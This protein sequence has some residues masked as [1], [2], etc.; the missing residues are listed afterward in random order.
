MINKV[1]LVGN[2]TRD[3]EMLA[4]AGKPMTKMRLATNHQWKD[5]DGNRQEAAEFHSVVAFGRLAEVC[6][7]Y[8]SKGRPVYLEG[9]L[10]TREYA[11]ADGLRRFSTEIVAETVKLLQSRDHASGADAAEEPVDDAAMAD[12]LEAGAGSESP[13]VA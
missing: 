8:C 9:R 2:M 1:I 12:A 7:Q 5:A 3:A 6:A 13:L 4:T 11:G 10:R